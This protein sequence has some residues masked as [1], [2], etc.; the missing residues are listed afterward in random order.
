MRRRLCSPARSP[1]S[2]PPASPGRGSSI[3]ASPYDDIP[4]SLDEPPPEDEL[5]PDDGRPAPNAWPKATRPPTSTPAREPAREQAPEPSPAPTPAPV[6][7]PA[8]TWEPAPARSTAPEPAPP[9]ESSRTVDLTDDM[10]SDD[11]DYEGAHL[12]GAKVV[13]D[14][15]GGRVVEEQ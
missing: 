12:V 5:P 11:L 2:A 14:V 9:V 1:R 13:Q 4:P 8:P 15:L 3:P 7:A 6:R 10:A